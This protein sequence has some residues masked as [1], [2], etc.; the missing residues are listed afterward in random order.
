MLHAITQKIQER[1]EGSSSSECYWK[2]I[3]EE[4]G[5]R[6]KVVLIEWDEQSQS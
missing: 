1:I 5:Q 2:C 3:V 6:K 4:F